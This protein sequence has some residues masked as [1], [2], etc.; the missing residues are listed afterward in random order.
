[1]QKSSY[2]VG[3]IGTI[4]VHLM[5]LVLFLE[6]S[7]NSQPD[8]QVDNPANNPVNVMILLDVAVPP[9]GSDATTNEPLY[10][11]DGKVCPPGAKTYLGV[12]FVYETDTGEIHQVPTVLPAYKA[13]IRTGDLLLNDPYPDAAGMMY[14]KILRGYK[15]INFEIKAAEICYSPEPLISA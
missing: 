10:T 11:A 3:V 9:E 14:I 7:S 13:G 8:K 15:Q 2:T 12:G 5:V 6:F 1:M 4:L